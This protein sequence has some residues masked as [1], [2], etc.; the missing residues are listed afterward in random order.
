M[1]SVIR[2]RFCVTAVLWVLLLSSCTPIEPLA[3]PPTPTPIAVNSSRTDPWVSIDS[4]SERVTVHRSG[5]P[6]II[7]ENAAFGAAGVKQKARRGD[8][9]TPTGRYT[10]GWISKQSRF[11]QFIGLNYP[12]LADAQRGL[13]NGTINQSVFERIAKAHARGATPPQDTPLGGMI[14]LHG[15]GR[16]SLEIHRLVNWTAGCIALENDQIRRLAT[17]LSPGVEVEI[18]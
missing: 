1:F 18:R 3:P 8:D 17:M 11:F 12:S 4:R 9:V 6:D 16:G 5:S 10:I 7:F 13:Q 2:S 14:G 15:V